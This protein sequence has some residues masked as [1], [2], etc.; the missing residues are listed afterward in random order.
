MK[1]QAK[2]FGKGYKG[3]QDN[4]LTSSRRHSHLGAESASASV[5]RSD[6]ITTLD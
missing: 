1:K 2:H 3:S 4:D 5:G 6:G